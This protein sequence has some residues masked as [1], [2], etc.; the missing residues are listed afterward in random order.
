MIDKF[1]V[2]NFKTKAS[3]TAVVIPVINE[4]TRLHLLLNR[5]H[6]I[7]I[8]ESFDVIITDGGSTDGSVDQSVLSKSGV[9]TLIIKKIKG[10]LGTQLQGA[11]DFCLKQGYDSVITIDGNNKDNPE[12]IFRIS[13]KLQEGFEFVQASRFIR[14]GSHENTPLLRLLA[15]RLV[16]AP[17]LTLASGFKWTDTTQGFRGYSRNL[18]EAD[19]LNIFN[20]DLYDYKLL[21][22]MSYAAPKLGFRCIEVPSQR[23]YP[24]NGELPT[25]I[26]GFSGNLEVLRGLVAVCRGEFG[27]RRV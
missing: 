26:K 3:S 24:D 10:K 9:T 16:H 2:S 20:P 22:Y 6:K 11:Y 19:R 21:F 17:L 7:G 8:F 5:M 15:I 4:G 25:K 18:L 14:G 23:D 27:P 1:E 12:G 13:K